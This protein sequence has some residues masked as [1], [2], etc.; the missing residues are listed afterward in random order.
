M[1]IFGLP[2]D[3][4]AED[5]NELRLATD[6]FVDLRG[7]GLSRGMFERLLAGPPLSKEVP[8]RRLAPLEMSNDLVVHPRTGLR[9][10]ARNS[11]DKLVFRRGAEL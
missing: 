6:F 5:F 9:F 11:F 7:A 2:K 3:L 4:L 8:K 1:D 10:R